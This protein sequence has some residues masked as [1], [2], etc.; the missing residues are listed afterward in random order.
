MQ[1]PASIDAKKV[2]FIMLSSINTKNYHVSISRNV[3]EE[4]EENETDPLDLI[5]TGLYSSSNQTCHSTPSTEV[6]SM[7]GPFSN[8]AWPGKV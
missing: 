7:S 4:R 1:S 5:N 8:H 6:S 3:R 2:R